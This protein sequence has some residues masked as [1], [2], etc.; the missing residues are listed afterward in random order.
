MSRKPCPTPP[1]LHEIENL[2][3]TLE[4]SQNRRLFRFWPIFAM[5]FLRTFFFSLYSLALPNYLIYEKNITPG[6]VG[7][8]SSIS[9]IAYIIGPLVGRKLTNSWGIKNTMILSTVLS[10][11]SIVTSIFFV[12]PWVLLVVRALDGFVNGFFW[13]NAINLVSTWEKRYESTSSIDFLR[14]F[15]NS[16]NFGLIGGYIFGYIFVFYLGDDFTVLI[17]SA[18]FAFLMIPSALSLERCNNFSVINNRAVVLQDFKLKTSNFDPE[19]PEQANR[20]QESKKSE[21]P[22]AIAGKYKLAALP[23]ILA[24]GGIFIY[25]SAKSILK[26]TLPF[27]FKFDEIDSSWVY[28][29]VLFQQI[30]QITGLNIMSRLS[31]KKKGYFF[32]LGILISVTTVML[33][34]PHALVFGILVIITGVAVGL[35]QGVTQRIIMDY[36]KHHST[37]KYSMWNEMFT[38]ISFGIMP[39]IAGFLL[40]IDIIYDFIFLLVILVS[41]GAILLRASHKYVKKFEVSD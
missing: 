9:A 33:F 31:T 11:L 30:M 26:F 17:I 37:T 10:F 13:P 8:I 35:M 4:Q 7:L 29:V 1:E 3:N 38:G 36:T 23:L 27:V 40:E 22:S 24:Y 25:A 18:G 32:G 20:L 12:I 28:F 14:R 34:T 15:N 5:S 16:W 41:V 6:L 39:T 21:D 19:D 2:E